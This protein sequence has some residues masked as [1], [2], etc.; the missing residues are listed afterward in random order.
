MRG[1]GGPIKETVFQRTKVLLGRLLVDGG[2]IFAQDLDRALERQKHTNEMLGEV[3]ICMGVLNPIELQA[4]L[5]LQDIL[6][7]PK[8]AVKVAAGVRE[9]LG[10]LLV[11]AKKIT[12]S[13]LELALK[14]Q[15]RTGEKLGAILVRSGLLSETE[16]NHFLQF[17]KSQ[18]IEGSFPGP[19]RLGEILIATNQISRRQME[20]A[21]QRQKLSK[22]KIGTILIEAGYVQ[23]W[24]VEFGLKL[25]HRLVTAAL[26]GMLYLSGATAVEA[27]SKN[28][29]TLTATIQARATLRILHQRGELVI[30]Q[31]DVDR[32]YVEVQRGS[33]IEVR[34]NSPGGYLLSF[35]NHGGLFKEVHI[36]GLDAQAQ[37]GPGGGWI[38]QSYTREAVVREL[39][40]RFILQENTQPGTYSWPLQITARP[41]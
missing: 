1:T 22:K 21:L 36:Q 11:R 10:T 25:Q 20:E 13:Q 41:R 3:L 8:D 26:A 34:N 6:N 35:E 30:T 23:P 40:Y 28:K 24:Q 12:N 19:L 2:F 31:G 29:V 7:S 18:E 32:G 5:A 39:N 33:R 17:Q 38:P 27:S 4:A 14:E 9:L 37:V 16:L 15:E